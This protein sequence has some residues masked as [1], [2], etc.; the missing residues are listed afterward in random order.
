MIY[1]AV[2]C[3]ERLGSSLVFHGNPNPN[4]PIGANIHGVLDQKLDR[5]L[6]VK[7]L[8]RVTW[9]HKLVLL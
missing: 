8:G 3:M 2:E 1:Q 9:V 5:N 4:C 6:N 7:L